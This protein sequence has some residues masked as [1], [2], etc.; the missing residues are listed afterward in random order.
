M[1]LTRSRAY[2]PRSTYGSPFD[3]L[4]RVIGG[5][6][7]GHSSTAYPAFNVWSNDDGAVITSEI[8]GARM[9][10]IELTVHGKTFTIKGGKKEEEE[11]VRYVRH[12]RP[13]GEFSRAIEL[14][15]Q[16]DGGKV[17]AKLTNGI[18]EIK[19]PRAENDK[20]RKIAVSAS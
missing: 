2:Y 3:M 11:S 6:G 4:N 1:F 10:D 14:P 7:A 16:I 19:L 20:P 12:E 15:F 17:E 13:D 5:S 18:L 8:P 9:E